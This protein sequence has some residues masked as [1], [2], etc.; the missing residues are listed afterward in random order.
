MMGV[1]GACL[2]AA[3]AAVL[4][5]VVVVVYLERLLSGE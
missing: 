1:L 4:V 5:F 3:V 2:G